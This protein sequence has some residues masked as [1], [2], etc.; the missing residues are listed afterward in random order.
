[1]R[2]YHGMNESF[3]FWSLDKALAKSYSNAVRNTRID[4][5]G[6]RDY[7]KCRKKLSVAALPL[8][9]STRVW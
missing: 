3:V 8:F 6:T 1:M 9:N 5:P 7:M 2:T 4:Q